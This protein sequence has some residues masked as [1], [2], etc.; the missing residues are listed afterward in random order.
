MMLGAVAAINL[1]TLSNH[2]DETSLPDQEF[3]VIT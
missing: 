2:H 1:T 3:S